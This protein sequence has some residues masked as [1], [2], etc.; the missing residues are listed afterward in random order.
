MTN[1]TNGAAGKGRTGYAGF[2]RREG[3]NTSYV[4]RVEVDGR[5]TREFKTSE[6]AKNYGEK[7]ETYVVS[8]VLEETGDIVE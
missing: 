4:F 8:T 2:M 3:W 6:A 5:K 1:F 7:H